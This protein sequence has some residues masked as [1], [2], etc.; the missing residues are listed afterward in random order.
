MMKTDLIKRIAKKMASNVILCTTV[1]LLAAA[2]RNDEPGES[3][4]PN[5]P[6]G[7]EKGQVTLSIHIPGMRTPGT[8]AVNDEKLGFPISVCAFKMEGGQE[9]LK[10]MKVFQNASVSGAPSTETIGS[11]LFLHLRG[12]DEDDYNRLCILTSTDATGKLTAGTSTFD[13]LKQLDIDDGMDPATGL[14]TKNEVPMYGELKLA[15]EN[16]ISVRIGQLK[17]YSEE[18]KFLRAMAC[19]SFTEMD[20]LDPAASPKLHFCRSVKNGRVYG[21]A[22]TY[23]TTLNMP[24][25]SQANV[26]QIDCGGIFHP[27]T[28]AGRHD[29]VFSGPTIYAYEQPAASD[30]GAD[31]PRIILEFTIRNEGRFFYPIDFIGDDNGHG[32]K[33]TP[34][35]IHRNHRYVFTIRPPETTGYPTL[36]DALTSKDYYTNKKMVQAELVTVDESYKDINFTDN[37]FLALS[38]TKFTFPPGT[39]HDKFKL[40]TNRANWKITAYDGKTKTPIPPGGWLGVNTSQGVAGTTEVSILTKKMGSGYLMVEA[41][42]LRCRLDVKRRPTPLEYGAEYNLAGGF[43]YGSK[44]MVPNIT[45]STP[46]HTDPQLRWAAN[47]NI[48]QSGYY[49]WYVLKGIHDAGYNPSTKNLF[50]DAFFTTG[51]GKGYHLPS[52]PELAGVFSYGNQI[53]FRTAAF[54]PPINEAVEF[55]GIKKTY[56]N[57]Y[58]CPGANVCYSLRFGQATGDPIEGYSVTEFPKATDNSMLCAYRYTLVGPFTYRSNSY[59]K[60]ECVYLGS[61][62]TGDIH[63]ISNDSWWGT[64]ASETVTRIFP[65]AGKLSFAPPSDVGHLLA[66]WG[67]YGYYWS[68]TENNSLT[69]WGRL[70]SL[71]HASSS[72]SGPGFD[73]YLDIK[74]GGQSVRLFAD[75]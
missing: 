11:G 5:P 58:K 44:P 12:L 22:N 20:M 27:H 19:I 36:E 46:A 43:Q 74:Y 42:K 6:A 45:I 69:A 17:S 63:T 16:G 29:W 62:F 25:P 30:M 56:L 70:F 34:I 1:L 8:R 55:G 28:T 64:R 13:N 49:N 52:V 7:K 71:Y 23:T 73:T 38:Q 59:L 41:G 37:Y 35:P 65:A 10:F 47:H 68:G 21:D 67:R 31:G 24:D 54:I 9:K 75:E 32:N 60:V 33:G 26:P 50:S 40:K 48:D 39:R 61:S 53:K 4:M 66:H 2:C 18:V 15:T 57:H 72:G 51:E 3:P 14:Y